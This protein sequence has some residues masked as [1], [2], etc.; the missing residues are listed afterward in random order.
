MAARDLQAF[1]E[2][3][4]SLQGGLSTVDLVKAAWAREG[5]VGARPSRLA[6]VLDAE[7]CLDRLYGGHYSDWSCGG[8]WNHMLDFLSVLFSSLQQANIHVATFIDGTSDPTKRQHWVAA[9]LKARQNVRQVLRHVGK[10]GTPPPKVW[11]VPPTGLRSVLRL[12]LRYLGVPVLASLEHHALEV[13]H[14]LWENGYHGLLGD[15]SEYC[16]FDPPKY[17]S[18]AKLKLTLKF[19]V[20]TQQVDMDEIAKCLDLNPNRFSLTA[21]LL[22]GEGLTAAELQ[23]FHARLIPGKAAPHKTDSGVLIRA[24]VNYVRTL[25]NVEDLEALGAEIFG[26]GDPRVAKLQAVVGYYSSGTAEGYKK[27]RQGRRKGGAATLASDT[28]EADLESK[29]WYDMV[30]QGKK[31][32]A[33]IAG[34]AEEAAEQLAGMTLEETD[35][36]IEPSGIVKDAATD[37]REAAAAVAANT[38]RA[39]EQGKYPAREAAEAVIPTVSAEVLRTAAERHR[40]GCMVPALHQLLTTGE[41]HLPVLMEE[42]GEGGAPRLAGGIHLLYRTLR[43]RVYGILFNEHHRMYTQGRQEDELAMARAKVQELTRK[44]AAVDPESVIIKNKEPRQEKE[45][46]GERLGAAR[47]VVEQLARAMGPGQGQAV[48]REWLPYSRYL[49]PDA[50]TPLAL[51]WPVPTVQ[52]LWFGAAPEDKQRRLRAFLSV[53]GADNPL[54]LQTSHVPQ[55]LLLMATVLRYIM[56]QSNVL[57]KPELDSFLITAFSPELLDVSYLARAKLDLLTPR[58]L[59]LAALFMEGVEM[60]LLAN[61]ACGAPVPF[62]MCAPWLFFDGG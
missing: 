39:S 37:S 14:F 26:R 61:D 7:T 43:R 22:G 16:I 32:A 51:E 28:K 38:A 34:E 44:M 41:L 59:Q 52:R 2:K 17:Y 25:V 4:P 48:V 24:V 29:D 19:T 13:I 42:Q 30:T 12:A 62:L 49:A 60:A 40:Q 15:S 50:V 20:E 3:E 53:M 47:A 46:L 55:H 31:A 58:G 21:G 10:R 57:R 6:L 54:M 5:K 33:L 23:E 9:Q 1:L 36:N 8:E 35:I 11:W 56:R 27:A 18:A 45:V